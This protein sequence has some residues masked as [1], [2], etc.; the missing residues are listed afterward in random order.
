MRTHEFVEV[1]GIEGRPGWL[2]HLR[3]VLRCLARER[4][5]HAQ[6]R[7]LRQGGAENVKL[8]HIRVRLGKLNLAACERG[9]GPRGRNVWR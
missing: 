4:V 7:L 9:R 1:L 5:D 6:L 8:V 2:G 3:A